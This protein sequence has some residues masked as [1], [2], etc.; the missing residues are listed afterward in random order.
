M[1][2]WPVRIIGILI[3]LMLFLIMFGM[4]RS[5]QSMVETQQAAPAR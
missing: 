1:S 4:I 3:I 2:K 5:L